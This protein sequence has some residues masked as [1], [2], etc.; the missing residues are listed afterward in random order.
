[1]RARSLGIPCEGVCSKLNSICDVPGVS[2]GHKTITRGD[3]VRT[4]VTAILPR[5]K[6]LAEGCF[7]AVYSWNG[8]GEMTGAHWIKESGILSLPI[9]LTN[10]HSVGICYQAI[11][12]HAQH[13]WTLIQKPLGCCLL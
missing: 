2:V 6:V 8:N 11:I 1:M 4:G 13:C 3:N 5:G 7:A 10:T 12:R 9:L